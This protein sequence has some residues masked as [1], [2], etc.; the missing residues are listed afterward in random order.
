MH[1][2]AH[3]YWELFESGLLKDLDIVIT[4]HALV[5][6]ELVKRNLKHS[7]TSGIDILS[8]KFFPG[9]DKKEED[10]LS[11]H[12]KIHKEY[13]KNPSDLLFLQHIYSEKNLKK[14][15]YS[16]V[17]HDDDLDKYYIWHNG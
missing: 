4:N 11:D 2:E 15:G 3:Y 13:A 12:E 1:Y 16:T 17:N 6:H 7:S 10:A 14:Y 8:Q 5:A 9:Y